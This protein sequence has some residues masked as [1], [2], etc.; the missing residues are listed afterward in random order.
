MIGFA[1]GL[2]N[3]TSIPPDSPSNFFCSE[4]S[5]SPRVAEGLSEVLE[6]DEVDEVKGRGVESS[7]V[8]WEVSM[9]GV[10]LLFPSFVRVSVCLVM[11]GTLAE[12]NLGS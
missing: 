3:C 11:V 2:S 10:I 8:I 12:S 6:R 4:L 7:E 9:T 1:G 5:L